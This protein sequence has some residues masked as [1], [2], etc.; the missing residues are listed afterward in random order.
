MKCAVGTRFSERLQGFPS[1]SAAR[2]D[3]GQRR[4]DAVGEPLW[5]PFS[6]PPTPKPCPEDD[7][8]DM[9]LGCLL[10]SVDVA[11]PELL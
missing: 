7:G 8:H 4:R 9:S 2:P 3:F 10:P 1:L 6:H 5:R 11:G